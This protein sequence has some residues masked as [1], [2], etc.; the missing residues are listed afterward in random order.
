MSQSSRV[1]LRCGVA[2]ATDRWLS[3][4]LL[5]EAVCGLRRRTDSFTRAVFTRASAP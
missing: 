1:K 4:F 3:L 5:W 2:G